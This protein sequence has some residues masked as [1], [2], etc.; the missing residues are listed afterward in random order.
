MKKKKRKLKST[1][2]SAKK[3]RILHRI[4]SQRTVS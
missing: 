1:S 4:L 2:I 3:F